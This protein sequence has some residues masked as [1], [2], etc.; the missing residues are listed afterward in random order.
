MKT[1]LRSAILSTVGISVAAAFPAHAQAQDTESEAANETANEN[2]IIVTARKQEEA[3]IDA[4]LAISVFGEEELQDAGFENVL[5]ISKASPGLFIEKF[6]QSLGRVDLTPRFRGVFLSTGSRLQQT[7]T[8]FLDGV[9]IS[10]GIE[11]I[12]VNEL[13]RVEI[14]KGPQSA[15][16]GRNTFAGAINYVTKDPA[17]EFRVEFHGSAATRGRYSIASSVEGPITDGISFRFGGSW[18]EK[19]GHYDN[20]VVPGEMLGDESQWNINGTLLIEPS[21]TVRLRVRGSYRE[22]HDGAPALINTFG[23][24][25]HNFGGFLLDSNCNRVSGTPSVQPSSNTPCSPGTERTGRNN[26]LGETAPFYGRTNSIFRGTIR[27]DNIPA[28][29]IGINTGLETIRAFRDAVTG[30]ARWPGESAALRSF[31]Y[32]PFDKDDFGLDL[33]ELRFSANLDVDLSDDILFSLLGGYSREQY[34]IWSELDL[35]PD[36]SLTTFVASEIDD[37]SIEGRLQGT[38]LNDR[39]NWAVG[40]S[41]VDVKI[42]RLGANSSNLFS[43]VVFGDAFRTEPFARGAE[44]LGFFG[45]LEYELVDQLSLTLEGRY[46]ED[47]IIDEDVN[48]DVPG[49]SPATLSNFVPRVTLRYEPSDATTV[50][51]TYSQGNLPGGFNPEVAEL[52]D[53]QLADVLSRVPSAGITF[54]EETL[55]NYE[56]GW[57]QIFADG[58]ARFN[59]ALFYMRRSDEIFRALE[60]APDT[61]PD[62]PNPRRTVAFNGNGAT[63]D[64]LGFELDGSGE[65]TDTLSVGLSI[66]YVDSSVASF[67]E[68]GGTDRFGLVFGPNESPVGQTAPRFPPLTFSTNATYADDVDWGIFDSWFMRGDMF[69]TGTFWTSNANLTKAADAIDVNLRFGLRGEDTELEF[70]ATNLFEEDAPASVQTFAHLGYDTRLRPGGFFNFNAIGNNIGLRDKREFGVRLK[71]TFR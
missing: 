9:S 16:F 18:S 61:S 2:V 37:F 59:L 36:N 39:L 33:D 56:L 43:T 12:G 4:P 30:D 35:T 69:Y 24:G 62:A 14:I 44:T 23:P 42:N 29:V 8:V 20:F 10:G 49:L 1:S 48:V 26:P 55:T 71:Y 63:T 58:R 41:Y 54:D 21:D 34:G 60:T 7:A 47:T 50:Y 15:L 3:L 5:D 19:Q 57:K 65:I 52:D 28:N 40:A 11:T 25:Q 22:V 70:F 6:N 45:S 32:N 67:P 51:A 27:G 31:K 68:N 64:I 66:A 46:Q 13:Q 38:V 53:V 17:D